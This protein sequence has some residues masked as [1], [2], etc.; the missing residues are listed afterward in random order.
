M[1]FD[2]ASLERFFK[3]VFIE[4]GT[5]RGWTVQKA[6][7]AGYEE[8]YTI[9]LSKPVYDAAVIKFKDH[10]NVFLFN[11]DTIQILPKILKDIKKPITFWLDAHFSDSNVIGLKKFPIIEELEIIKKAGVKGCNVLIDD[12]RLIEK[13]WN[14]KEEQIISML[15]DI[16][17]GF[18]FCY[19]DKAIK[20]DVIVAYTE[21]SL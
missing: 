3:P 10:K 1:D 12:R 16:D 2:V 6:I 5:W 14:L 8:I 17:P 18:K 19:L 15:K 7:E 21:G 9:E 20:D 4:T 13:R 11:G